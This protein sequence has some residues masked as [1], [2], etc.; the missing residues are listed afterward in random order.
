[1]PGKFSLR[2]FSDIDLNDPF[3]DSLKNDYQGSVKTSEFTTW[4]NKKA[5]EK[6]TALVF[7]DDVELGAF[8]AIKPEVEQIEP[9]ELTIIFDSVPNER[10]STVAHTGTSPS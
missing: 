4:F 9:D 1:M 3:F 2:Y 6:R 8:I 10:T 5:L 7:N